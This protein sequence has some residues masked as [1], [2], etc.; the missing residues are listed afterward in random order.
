[1][2][3]RCSTVVLLLPGACAVSKLV[4]CAVLKHPGHESHGGQAV[5]IG[6][7]VGPDILPS[8]SP[9]TF[10]SGSSEPGRDGG[11]LVERLHGLV[12]VDDVVLLLD[13]VVHMSWIDGRVLARGGRRHA[14]CRPPPLVV[15][16][17]LNDLS[18][19]RSPD[20]HSLLVDQTVPDASEF[21]RRGTSELCAVLHTGLPEE[22]SACFAYRSIRMG[23]AD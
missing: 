23:K 1:M 6:P 19:D 4:I 21:F 10:P 11:P 8:V 3:P 20:C 18:L 13:Q 9:G 7:G 16:D 22:M 14:P 5:G 2:R 15:L 17:A 12:V